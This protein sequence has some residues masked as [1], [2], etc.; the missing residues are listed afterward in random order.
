[1]LRFGSRYWNTPDKGYQMMF[2]SRGH[3][4]S[5]KLLCNYICNNKA[6]LLNWKP[7]CA[8]CSE[9]TW[10]YQG[11]ERMDSQWASVRQPIVIRRCGSVVSMRR[12]KSRAWVQ[13]TVRFETQFGFHDFGIHVSRL[14]PSIFTSEMCKSPSWFPMFVVPD[15]LRVLSCVK[16]SEYRKN[17]GTLFGILARGQAPTWSA[18]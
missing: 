18:W 4:N 14:K 13:C 10:L 15:N 11:W 6:L 1:M 12:I 8:K 5:T 17:G 16:Y 7:S 3:F 9:R 2:R